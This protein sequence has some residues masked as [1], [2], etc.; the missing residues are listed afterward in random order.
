MSV[1]AAVVA[2]AHVVAALVGLRVGLALLRGRTTTTERGFATALIAGAAWS[3]T[4]AAAALVETDV[5]QL[6]YAAVVVPAVATAVAGFAC[7][8][9]ALARV[10]WVPGRRALALLSVHPVTVLVLGATNPWHHLMVEGEL[11]EGTG[12]LS[13]GPFFVAHSVVAYGILLGVGVVA[14]LARRTAPALRSRQLTAVVAVGALPGLG[15]GIQL[16]VF[17]RT[18]LDFG[19]LTFVIVGLV[20]A[21]LIFRKN[22][23]STLPIARSTVIETIRDGILVLDDTGVVVDANAAALELLAPRDDAARPRAD[24]VVGRVL[25]ETLG[26]SDVVPVDVSA[27]GERRRIVLPDGATVVDVRW[28]PIVSRGSRVG[29]VVVMRDVTVDVEHEQVLARTNLELREHVATIERL[30]QEVAEQAV[31]DAVTGLHNRRHLDTVLAER[32]DSATDD[33]AALALAIIDADHFKLVNDLHG[34]AAGDRVLEALAHA[35]TAGVGPDDVLVRY[36]GE[37]FVVV[38][39]G[40]D[41][42][43]AVDRVERLRALCGATSATTRDGEVGV[44][45]SAGLAFTGPGR[46]TA[47]SLLDA[48]DRA[49]YEAKRSGRDRLCLAPDPQPAPGVLV[50]LRS[51]ADGAESS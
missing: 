19:A 8:T 48:A 25:T 41:E 33:G 50:D 31:R 47:E 30:R 38:M 12:T 11:R 45:V 13:F 1:E 14:V 43:A 40:V 3:S 2:V 7:G 23:L 24:A 6:L 9:F 18:L 46:T 37:E 27:S 32:L 29:V 42:A 35:L 15:T 5:R 10:D 16:A 28:A 26:R 49:L 20:D 22:A 44:T 17:P 4:A 51:G 36:G 21:Y 39:S 34:H